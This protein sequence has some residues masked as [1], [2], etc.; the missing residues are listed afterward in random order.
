MRSNPT[1]NGDLDLIVV[2]DGR[3]RLGPADLLAMAGTTDGGLFMEYQIPLIL[4]GETFDANKVLGVGVISEFD[5]DQMSPQRPGGMSG[6]SHGGKSGGGGG[7]GGGQGGGRGGQSMQGSRPDQTNI[8]V[9][10][11]VQLTP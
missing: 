6:G 2:D 11:K 1:F 5:M 4:L 9:W 10:L 7:K 3:E 8:D